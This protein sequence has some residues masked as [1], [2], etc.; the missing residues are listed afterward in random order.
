MSFETAPTQVGAVFI[1]AN[2]KRGSLGDQRAERFVEHH[3]LPQQPAMIGAARD[4]VLGDRPQPFG[5]EPPGPRQC[6][7]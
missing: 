4:V 7:A 5:I 3:Q 2:A 6:G 1:W